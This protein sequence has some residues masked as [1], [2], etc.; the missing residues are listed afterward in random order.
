MKNSLD[1]KKLEEK[2][3]NAL[4]NETAESLTDFI[5]SKR[6]MKLHLTE[7]TA[8]ITDEELMSA[9]EDQLNWQATGKR[10]HENTVVDSLIR[11]YFGPLMIDGDPDVSAYKHASCTSAA[12]DFVCHEIAKRVYLKTFIFVR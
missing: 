3:D 11:E 10:L 12:Y 6:K 9:V 7:F 1:L 4:S 2:L 8:K 5:L